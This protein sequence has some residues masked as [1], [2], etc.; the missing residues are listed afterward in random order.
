VYLVISPTDEEPE[1]KNL[2]SYKGRG[3]L[4]NLPNI[5]PVGD[6]IFVIL[7]TNKPCLKEHAIILTVNKS[8]I[9]DSLSLYP[10]H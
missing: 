4:L 2:C 3:L 6:T 10:G 7:T 1:I 5:S 9:K 8:V